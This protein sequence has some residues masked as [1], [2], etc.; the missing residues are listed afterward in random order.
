MRFFAGSDHAGFALKRHLVEWLRAA[1]HEVEDLGTH[2]E[3]STDY[4]DW[5]HRV[6]ERV[7]AERV[8]GE[9][10]FGLLVCGTG[11]GVSISA[12]RHAG[13]RAALCTDSFSAR[14]ARAHNDA[15]VLCLGSRVVGVGLAESILGAFVEGTFE[16]GRHAGR[17]AKIDR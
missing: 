10:S 15:N 8:A 17:V 11:I 6:A 13:I 16:G 7:A 1:G 3:S 14:M 5:A 9:G 4:P 2:D 12:N